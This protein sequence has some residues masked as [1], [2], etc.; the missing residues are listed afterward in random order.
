MDSGLSCHSLLESQLKLYA[1]I[2]LFI[3]YS[4]INV[5]VIRCFSGSLNWTYFMN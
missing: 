4:Y 1:L 5:T 3:Y 2:Y